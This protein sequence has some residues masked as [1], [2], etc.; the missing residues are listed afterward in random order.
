[1]RRCAVLQYKKKYLQYQFIKI[2]AKNVCVSLICL[3]MYVIAALITQTK[4]IQFFLSIYRLM[5]W[6]RPIGISI[7][8]IRRRHQKKKKASEKCIS[9]QFISLTICIYRSAIHREG[10][11]GAAGRCRRAKHTKNKTHE[12][13]ERAKRRNYKTFIPSIHLLL[14]ITPFQ[15]HS[16]SKWF[17]QLF[18]FTFMVFKMIL[19]LYHVV[20]W[21]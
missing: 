10:G 2:T 19:S 17:F 20:F 1:M 14:F 5:N 4:T 16:N 11:S 18:I 12:I 6:S 21:V 3:C 8:T 15:F 13:K 9:L 7:S